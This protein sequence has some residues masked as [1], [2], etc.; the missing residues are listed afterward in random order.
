MSDVFETKAK[1]ISSDQVEVLDSNGA[2]LAGKETA[3]ASPFSAGGF[4]VVKMG[5]VGTVAGLLI[6]PILIPLAIIGFFLMMIFAMLFGK[7]FV[8]SGIM[9]VIKR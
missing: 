5:P 9:K 4:K 1:K 8:K 6:L 7:T 3:S 2:H